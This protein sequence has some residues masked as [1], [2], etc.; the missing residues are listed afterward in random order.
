MK[1]ERIQQLS[2]IIPDNSEYYSLF[3]ISL[4]TGSNTDSW[5]NKFVVC[6]KDLAFGYNFIKSFSKLKKK[7]PSNVT[8]KYLREAYRF[9]RTGKAHPSIVNAYMYRHPMNEFFKTTLESMLL[10]DN[11]TFEEISKKT[12]ISVSTI[13]AYEQLFFNIVDRKNELA[14]V[15]SIVYPDSRMVEFE[16]NYHKNES[17]DMILKRSAYN[18]GLEDVSW[19]LGFKTDHMDTDIDS[20]LMTKKLEAA[21]MANG[22]YLAK[23]GFLN[24]RS[25]VGVQNAKN[26]ISAGKQG[27]QEVE[28]N[29]VEGVGSLGASFLDNYMTDN[30]NSM[31]KYIDERKKIDN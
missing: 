6:Y 12:G 11:I 28:V 25:S 9:E 31:N 1:A 14:F 22:Y 7:L 16:E 2:K 26:I 3:P 18:N 17:R 5:I 13:K 19:L 8:E 29:D 23:N 21:I 30:N 20:N 10:V 15:A 4:N 27:G 24:Q